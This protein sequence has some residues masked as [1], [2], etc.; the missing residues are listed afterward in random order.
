MKTGILITARMGSTRLRDKHLR[1]V[2]GRPVLAWLV[3]R[4]E[5][6][7]AAEIAAGSVVPVLATGDEGRNAPLAALC[8]G[9]A[10]R[11]FYGDDD[12][13]PRRHLQAAEALGLDAM[14]SVDGDDILCDPQAMREVQRL[15]AGGAQVAKTSGLPLGMN[16]WGY[17]RGALQ[18][19]LAAADLALLETGWGRIFEG[20]PAQATE[21]PCPQAELVRATLDYDQDLAFFKRC[22]E[23]IDG[24]PR[25]S[26]AA[27]VREIVGRGIND[28]NLGVSETYWENFANGISKETNKD[29]T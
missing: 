18:A 23:E 6:E 11:M 15:L 22:I 17:S 24:W 28:E 12:N 5:R 1:P 4:I 7:F 25:L 21:L 20:L 14:V 9:S 2:T 19:A 8:E 26:A 29:E 27:L 13:V 10:L 3:E 16:S